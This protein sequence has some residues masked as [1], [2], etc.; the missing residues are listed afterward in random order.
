[1]DELD[2]NSDLIQLAD[3]IIHRYDSLSEHW[4]NEVIDALYDLQSN[5]SSKKVSYITPTAIKSDLNIEESLSRIVESVYGKESEKLSGLSSLLQICKNQR[6]LDIVIR[7]RSLMPALARMLDDDC[8]DNI[9]LVSI[10]VQI[11]ASLSVF[12]DFHRDLIHNHI[13]LSIMTLL[14]NQ[15]NRIKSW[16]SEITI[17]HIPSSGKPIHSEVV[18]LSLSVL[19]HL[20]D[21]PS[22]CRKMLRKGLIALLFECL[23]I[24]SSNLSQTA[25]KLLLKTSIYEELI[26]LSSDNR[27]FKHLLQLLKARDETVQ[28]NAVLIFYNMSF[29][30]RFHQVVPIHDVTKE[31]FRMLHRSINLRECFS[32]LYQWSR[33]KE[34]RLS[35]ALPEYIDHIMGLLLQCQRQK[36]ATVIC[37]IVIH[38]RLSQSSSQL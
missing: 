32:L 6:H 36:Y 17:D 27:S 31:V 34:N 11:I 22:I 14:K 29:F 5:I 37:A 24:N 38:V 33:S 16:T 19:D 7:H 20:S 9:A 21:D 10:I 13:G 1:M 25:S 15:I 26:L 8:G 23:D 18:L 35:L 28:R 4:R 12:A 2:T 30:E 3:D